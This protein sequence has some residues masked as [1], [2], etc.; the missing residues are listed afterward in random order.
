MKL[1]TEI[2]RQLVK[3]MHILEALNIVQLPDEEIKPDNLI[4]TVSNGFNPYLYPQYDRPSNQ[5]A[6]IFARAIILKNIFPNIIRCDKVHVLKKQCIIEL[7]RIIAI[8]QRVLNG[9]T[10]KE[11]KHMAIYLQL[12]FANQ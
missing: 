7:N 3:Y 10:R 6:K 4:G 11:I 9:H 12:R 8:K 1:N 2:E 5:E